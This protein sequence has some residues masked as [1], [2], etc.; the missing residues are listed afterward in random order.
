MVYR[1]CSIAI[2]CASI[3]DDD[4]THSII[5]SYTH[6]DPKIEKKTETFIRKIPL[7]VLVYEGMR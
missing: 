5:W 6:T 1:S 7:L 4:V 2:V 3:D